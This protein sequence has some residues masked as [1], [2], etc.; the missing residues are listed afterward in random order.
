[1]RP[2][3]YVGTYD[4]FVKN[5]EEEELIVLGNFDFTNKKPYGYLTYHQA[6]LSDLDSGKILS[7]S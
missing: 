7:I 5:I 4:Q 6:A 3:Y 1:V 2:L